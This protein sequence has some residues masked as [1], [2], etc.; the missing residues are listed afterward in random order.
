MAGRYLYDW[1]PFLDWSVLDALLFSTAFAGR[2]LPHNICGDPMV[3]G[4]GLYAVSKKRCLM[5]VNPNN[6]RSGAAR[7]GGT[8]NKVAFVPVPLA[9]PVR[10]CELTSP[11]GENHRP[12][13]ASFTGCQWL[14][15]CLIRNS[16][17]NWGE[18]I[19][20]LL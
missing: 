1:H 16:G 11:F 17:V 5:A 12:Q 18:G 9:M 6:H 8:V 2:Q 20:N 4:D 19:T 3:F 10:E 7:R 14:C 15:Q 13:H